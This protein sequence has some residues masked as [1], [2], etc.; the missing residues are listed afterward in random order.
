MG[1][2][3]VVKGGAGNDVLHG[4]DGNDTLYGGEGNDWLSPSCPSM[5]IEF[6]S[7]PG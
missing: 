5:L 7:N 2:Q 4:G 1:L 3:D 6:V